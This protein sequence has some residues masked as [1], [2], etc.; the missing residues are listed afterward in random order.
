MI[1]A[2]AI[3]CP[4]CGARFNHIAPTAIAVMLAIAVLYVSSSV[5]GEN[6]VGWW[7]RVEFPACLRLAEGRRS[8]LTAVTFGAEANRSDGASRPMKRPDGGIV[9][10]E[11]LRIT[12]QHTRAIPQLEAFEKLLAL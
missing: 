8:V 3:T 7:I 10:S 6:P 1:S 11:E 5:I 12:N 4:R 2:D 9:L